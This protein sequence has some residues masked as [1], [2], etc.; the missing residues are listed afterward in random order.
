[1]LDINYIREN[2][3]KVK[4]AAK[5][6][7]RN[8]DAVDRVLTLD[9]DRRR[10]IVT[11][12][13]IRS[14]RNKLNDELKKGR[15]DELIAKSTEL[16]TQLQDLEP[17]LREVEKTFEEIML[18]IPNV[19]F[20]EVPVGK[21]ETGNKTIRTWGDKPK[22]DFETK[23]HIELAKDLDLI[24]FERGTKVAGFRGYFLKGDAVM[25]QFAL[26]HYTLQK[27]IS[28]GYTPFVPPVILKRRNF[29][30]SAHFP[31]SE[32]DVY[33]FVT[34]E[35]EDEYFLTGT[36][37]VPLV[38]YYQDEV[39][40]EKDLPIKMIGFSPC[41]RK[42][43]GSYGRDT[44][45]VYRVHEFVKTEQVVLCKNDVE[46]SLRLHEEMMA[47]TEEIA[48][49]LGLPYRVLLMCTGDMGE[50][51]TK[52][53][54]LEAWMPGR[55][56]WGELASDSIVTDFQSRRAN[57]RY[58]DA[59]NEMQYVHMLNNTASN[60]PRWLVAILENYQQ[61]DGSI[62]IPAVLVP[63]MGKDRIERV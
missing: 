12:E 3:D 29:V 46:E 15:T 17:R 45:G 37:E 2:T 44:Q 47:H 18:Q 49:E 22:F 63:Y 31:W 5:N 24:D 62:K 7:N 21:D 56:N 52:K 38:S 42:E 1:M 11:I 51:Q 54:D 30:N 32:Q 26:M 14:E 41:Y 10:L 53:Y 40:N 4:E 13:S 39:L 28:K 34:D 23:N 43:A 50:P 6:K 57:I 27:F 58:R 19:P 48:Q 33:K 35:G 55:D 25:L 60:S 61:A 59:K 20:D 8:A 36:A 16:K 9:S